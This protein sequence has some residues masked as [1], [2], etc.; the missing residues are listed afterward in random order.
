M[1]KRLPLYLLIAFIVANIL[2]MFVAPLMV[3]EKI[4]KDTKV[5]LKERALKRAGGD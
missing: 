4:K 1:K 2:Y 3:M 5:H